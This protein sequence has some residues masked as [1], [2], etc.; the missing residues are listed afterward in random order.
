MTSFSKKLNILYYSLPY[1]FFEYFYTVLKDRPE[2]R[3]YI[4][5]KGVIRKNRKI[6]NIDSKVCNLQ[7]NLFTFTFHIKG[8]PNRKLKYDIH[9][10]SK[11][12]N[13]KIKNYLFL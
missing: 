9:Y 10:S 2:I 7:N 5:P 6:S 13:Y 1:V 12:K 4:F 8:V 3:T 11:R